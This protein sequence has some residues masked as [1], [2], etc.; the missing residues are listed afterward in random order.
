MRY[1]I[2]QKFSNSYRAEAPRECCSDTT[3]KYNSPICEKTDRIDMGSKIANS[4]N[5]HRGT[6]QEVY[7]GMAWWNGFTCCLDPYC[8]VQKLRHNVTYC[9]DGKLPTIV[10]GKKYCGVVAC[11]NGYTPSYSG[12]NEYCSGQVTQSPVYCPR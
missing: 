4:K 1:S 3:Y 5:S 8:F 2:P 6:C 10:G 9:N 7:G 11:Q 12:N